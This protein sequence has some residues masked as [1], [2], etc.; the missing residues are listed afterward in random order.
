MT[1]QAES[2]RRQMLIKNNKARIVTRHKRQ[3]RVGKSSIALNSCDCAQPPRTVRLLSTL[4][5][6]FPILM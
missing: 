1:D 3:G 6:A 4:I 2:L 5:L